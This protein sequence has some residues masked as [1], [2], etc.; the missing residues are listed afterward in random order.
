M[1]VIIHT[2]GDAWPMAFYS[3][4]NGCKVLSK[5]HL[6]IVDIIL[7]ISNTR[8]YKYGNCFQIWNVGIT[9]T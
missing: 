4:N 7:F 9:K 8:F 2:S 5:L 3:F 1:R 6:L